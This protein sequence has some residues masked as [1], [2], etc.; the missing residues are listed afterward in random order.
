MQNGEFS[1]EIFGEDFDVSDDG[2]SG[3]GGESSEFMEDYDDEL[4]DLDTFAVE[5]YNLR[6]AIMQKDDMIGLLGIMSASSTA[7]I[8]R[9][10]PREGTPAYQFYEDVDAAKSWF[11]KSLGTS[12]RNG[13]NILYDG[14]PLRG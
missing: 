4:G 1:D 8:C 6:T 14:L 7:T 9:V 12:R 2:L 13:W 11:S 5:E 3:I 10:D